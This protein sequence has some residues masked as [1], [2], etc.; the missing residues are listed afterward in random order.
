MRNQDNFVAKKPTDMQTKTTIK[1]EGCDSY[2]DACRTKNCL[3][4]YGKVLS[5]IKKN[6]HY[7]PDPNA[8]TVGNGT[9][10][11]K[12]ILNRQIPN[13]IPAAGKKLRISY[14]GC[15]FLCSNCFR[16]HSRKNCKNQ[17]VMWIHYVNRFIANN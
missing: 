9:Y 7:D 2:E 8:E 17:K 5:E 11:V 15:T 4:Y 16:A 6:T 10:L 14:T 13:F 3:A 12:M 1:I